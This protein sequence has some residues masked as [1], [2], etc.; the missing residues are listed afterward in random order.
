MTETELHRWGM[1]LHRFVGTFGQVPDG[2]RTKLVFNIAY[3]RD[4]WSRYL[5]PGNPCPTED[6][7]DM[8]IVSIWVAYPH[9]NGLQDD[10]LCFD[11]TK[12]MR[13]MQAELFKTPLGMDCCVSGTVNFVGIFK[14]RLVRLWLGSHEPFTDSDYRAIDAALLGGDDLEDDEDGDLDEDDD[15]DDEYTV[16]EAAA[17]MCRETLKGLPEQLTKITDAVIAQQVAEIPLRYVED[18]LDAG[19]G[20]PSCDGDHSTQPLVALCSSCCAHE[21]VVMVSCRSRKELVAT[22]PT[23][24]AMLYRVALANKAYKLN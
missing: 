11:L 7:T 15:E 8:L 21:P 22:C 12:L 3:A 13:A 20:D 10:H 2:F 4:T 5:K 1:K 18:I 14:K 16:S 23:C 9:H 19:C 6:E 17:V 24:G